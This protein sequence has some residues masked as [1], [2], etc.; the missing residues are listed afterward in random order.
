M[1]EESAWI[2]DDWLETPIPVPNPYDE[3]GE[4]E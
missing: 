3:E 4:Q 1:S 2:T